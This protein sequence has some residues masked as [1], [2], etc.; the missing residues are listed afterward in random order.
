MQNFGSNSENEK[1]IVGGSFKEITQ[2]FYK[3]GVTEVSDLFEIGK[4]L[5]TSYKLG[6][7]GNSESFEF[8]GMMLDSLNDQLSTRFSYEYKE[9]NNACFD[10]VVSSFDTLIKF[11]DQYL[12]THEAPKSIFG[13][14][15]K[16]LV[17]KLKSI[18]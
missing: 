16:E 6:R 1:Q 10:S 7:K 2:N 18:A 11:C 9:Q 8:I 5:G 4:K 15:R 13:K 12:R 17:I 3:F 14:N